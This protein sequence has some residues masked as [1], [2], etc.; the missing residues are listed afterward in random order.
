MDMSNLPP[1]KQ[2]I[3]GLILAAVGAALT[4]FI[5]YN[6][7]QSGSFIKFFAILFPMLLV[8]GMAMAILGPKMTAGIP[9]SSQGRPRF[10]DYPLLLK[11]VGGGAIAIGFLN[12][13]ILD[14]T[15]QF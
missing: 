11:V 15:I 6:A 10:R 14:G 13:L 8:F 3:L 5:W 7:M 12:L 2:R 1:A 4:A 9:D